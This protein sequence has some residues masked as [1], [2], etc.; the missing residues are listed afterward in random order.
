MFPG[1]RCD[2]YSMFL[3]TNRFDEVPAAMENKQNSF[4]VITFGPHLYFHFPF[5]QNAIMQLYGEFE[6]RVAA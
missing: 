1:C 2:I 4:P 5:C 6:G 3:K